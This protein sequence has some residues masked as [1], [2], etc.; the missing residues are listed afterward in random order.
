MRVEAVATDPQVPVMRLTDRGRLRDQVEQQRRGFDR[1]EL[2]TFDAFQRRAFALLAPATGHAFE[3]AAEPAAVRA[4]LRGDAV[5]R[6]AGWPAAARRSR[7][8]DRQRAF[9]PHAGR[10]VGHARSA[11]QPD[12]ERALSDLRP[13]VQALVDDLDQRRG[14]LDTTLV[15]ATAEF[16]RTP[17]A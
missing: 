7:R 9:L 3:L 15:L 8:A 2:Q 4:R 14:L 17:R 5:H 12:E 1:A 11:L 10:F 13:G 6:H 16:G